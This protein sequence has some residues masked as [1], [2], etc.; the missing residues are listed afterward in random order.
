MVISD[1]DVAAVQHGSAGAPDVRRRRPERAAAITLAVSLAVLT[2]VL[3]FFDGTGLFAPLNWV[4]AGFVPTHAT[5]PAWATVTY[6]PLLIIGGGLLCHRITGRLRPGTSAGWA[7]WVAWSSLVL[8]ALLAKIAYTLVLLAVA[9]PHALHLWPTVAA[10]LAQ[11]GLSAAKVAT[12]GLLAAGPAALAYRL[13]AGRRGATAEPANAEPA[14]AEPAT[15]EPANAEPATAE[16]ATAPEA[17]VRLWSPVWFVG[18]AVLAANATVSTSAWMGGSGH[19]FVLPLAGL[20]GAV[21]VSRVVWSG[22]ARR[23]PAPVGGVWALCATTVGA[24]LL[25][26]LLPWVIDGVLNGFGG[27]LFPIVG[28]LTHLGVGALAGGLTC[29]GGLCWSLVR[30]RTP[31]GRLVRPATGPGRYAGYAL[32]VAAAVGVQLLPATAAEPHPV[33]ASASPDGG[34]LLPLTVRRGE[35]PVIADA[36]GRQVLLRGVNVNQLIDYG[37][38]DPAEPTVRPLTEADYERMAAVYGFNV[39]RLGLSWSSLEP[40]RGEF[41]RAYL[42]RVRTAVDQAARHGIYTVLDIH[43]DT[44]SKYVTATPGTTCRLGAEPA[45]GNDG[46]PQWAT[47]TN[48][49]KGCGFMGRD[50]SPNVQQAFTN[51]YSDTDGIGAEF[52]R[53]WAVLANEF[54]GDTAV[55]GYDLLNEPGP[56][57]APG[58]TSSLLLGRLYQQVISSIRDAEAAVPGGFH[59]LVMFEPSILW[60]GLGFD[61]APPVGFSDDP[62]LVFSPH[63][64]N[65]SITMDQGLGVTLTT[66]EHGYTMARRAADAYGVPLWSGEW[67]WFGDITTR[68]DRYDRFLSEQNR[69]LLGSAVW[70][71]KK[72]CG[73]PQTAQGDALSGGLNLLACPAGTEVDGPAF[74]TPAL[75]QAYPRAAPGRLTSLR[76]SATTVDLRLSGTGTGVLEVWIPGTTAPT[77]DATG[78]AQVSVT[79]GADGG[80]RLTAYAS[81]AYTLA[82]R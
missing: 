28:A 52:A 10:V 31:V 7:F 33:P 41:D 44:Y 22:L 67:G 63:L 18:G 23:M 58:V 5:S 13:S 78:L 42:A 73:D 75:A 60:S 26:F 61:A 30:G 55:A 40:R 45:F 79:P 8:T 64:Y 57:N 12:L 70:V 29:A 69:H 49:A 82:L 6:L 72:S 48:G 50:L 17:P 36:A 74:L 9:G 76:S 65:E 59:H 51:L 39:Q 68:S 81:G 25:G 11:C 24:S 62:S 43:Q 16:P 32:A 53:A 21:F 37:Q 38:R 2:G 54:A 56:G 77:V 14:T 66:I 3:G 20:V 71:W 1:R 46:A 80:W 34:G 15:A 27:G 19:R 35:P 4:D 47:I